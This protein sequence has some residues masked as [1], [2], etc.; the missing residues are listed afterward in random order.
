MV[1]IVVE[2]GWKDGDD[3]EVVKV[4]TFDEHPHED[5]RLTVLDQRLK[6]LADDRLKTQ[7]HSLT[8]TLT[9]VSCQ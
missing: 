9:V 2:T 8:E 4:E 7:S 3:D 5:D 1:D 6:T